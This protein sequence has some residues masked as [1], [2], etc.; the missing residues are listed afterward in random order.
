MPFPS[1]HAARVIAPEKF[2]QDSFRRVNLTDGID[3]IMGKKIGGDAMEIQAYR[4]ARAKFTP[5][6]AKKWLKDHDAKTI[7]FEEASNDEAN[8]AIR[9][10]AGH[11]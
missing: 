2:Q 3:A 7:G 4:F 11:E 9:K 10:M 8:S 5:A 6:Q 1:E